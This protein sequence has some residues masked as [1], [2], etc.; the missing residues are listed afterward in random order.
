MV[1]TL[2]A[3][4]I[5][6]MTLVS[7]PKAST[8]QRLASAKPR[9]MAADYRG[10]L[11]ELKRLRE[12]VLALSGDPELGYL[13]HYWAGFASWR[14]AIN[15]ANVGMS[16]E[17]TRANLDAAAADFDASFTRKKDFADSYAAAASVNGWLVGYF[18]ND[19]DAMQK[20]IDL[21]TRLLKRA[22]E[23]EPDNPRVLWVLGG[24][25]YFRPPS[26]GGDRKKA[27]EVY[28]RAF[29]VSKDPTTSPL[30]DWGK[31]EALMALAFAHVTQTPPDV[32]SANEE[33]RAALKLQP[34]WSYVRNILLPQI[35]KAS[36]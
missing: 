17:E 26:L 7:S 31:P 20:Q 34:E 11:A 12:E 35:E 1:N 23:L 22:T 13:A 16:M 14:I 30:P 36:Q 28:R 27:V 3:L 24:D 19:K 10:N 6:V 33:A 2:I 25:Y 8:W 5:L 29:E 15:G 21:A 9:I 18:R 4:L 32:A